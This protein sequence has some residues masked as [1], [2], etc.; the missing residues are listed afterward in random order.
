V[1]SPI[2]KIKS[3][4][5]VHLVLAQILLSSQLDIDLLK[6]SEELKQVTSIR[7]N[8]IDRQLTEQK[9]LLSG[10]SGMMPAF[11]FQRQMVLKSSG[12]E[13]FKTSFEMLG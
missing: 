5:Y 8:T 11:W 4:K 10:L 6:R 2:N 1:Q 3:P 13:I 9:I 7:L 12:N